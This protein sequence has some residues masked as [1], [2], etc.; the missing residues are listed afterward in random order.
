MQVYGEINVDLYCLSSMHAY[1][2]P[3]LLET[4]SAKI[5]GLTD[6]VLWQCIVE[7][8]FREEIDKRVSCQAQV[9]QVRE[10]A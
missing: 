7:K 4:H 1:M 8:L 10:L 6:M 9:G 5:G 3:Q 2:L